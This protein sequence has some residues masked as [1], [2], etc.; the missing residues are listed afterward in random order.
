MSVVND[1]SF[2]SEFPVAPSVIAVPSLATPAIPPAMPVPVTPAPPVVKRRAERS[3][4]AERTTVRMHRLAE[5]RRQQGVSVRSAARRMGV[6]ME[7]VR[8]EERPTSNLTLA[9]LARWQKAMEVPL[10]DMLVEQNAPL[11]SPVM[12]RARWVRLMKTVRALS[13]V[14]TTPQVTRMV[15]MLE[16]QV[17]EVMPELQDVVAWHS[18]GQRRTQDEVGRIAEHPVSSMFAR[19]SLQ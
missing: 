13:E 17:L 2:G 5:I 10:I 7:Q 4:A 18:V 12:S 15:E 1:F 6:P 8:R 16:Q 19:D 3:G 14:A 9:D 11:S